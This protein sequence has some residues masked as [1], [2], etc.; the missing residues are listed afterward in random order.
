MLPEQVDRNGLI[1]LNRDECLRLLASTTIGRVAVSIGALPAVFPVNFVVA[2]G[3]VIFQTTQ[4]TKLALAVENHVVAF[5]VDA[6]DAFSHSGWSVLVTGEASV[7]DAPH[8]L[9][10][11]RRLP[12][13]AWAFPDRA[14]FV[15]VKGDV[16]TGRRLDP[17]VRHRPTPVR[18]EF[19]PVTP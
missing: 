4:G 3:D 13:L 17:L 9:V 15:R 8:E 11:V 16:I 14:S 5:E 1:V 19:A 7:I 10:A 2:D 12:L 6:I 18:Q